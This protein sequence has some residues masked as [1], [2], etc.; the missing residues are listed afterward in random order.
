MVKPEIIEKLK[1]EQFIHGLTFDAIPV[2]AVAADKTLEIC[3]KNNLYDNVKDKG[4]K[5]EMGLKTRLSDHPNVGDIRGKG[6]M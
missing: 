6:C 5:L 3:E 2:G 4:Q 1:T